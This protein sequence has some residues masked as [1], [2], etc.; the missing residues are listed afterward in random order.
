MEEQ[1][2]PGLSLLGQAVH[3][4]TIIGTTST[5]AAVAVVVVAAAAVAAAVVALAV[6]AD[7][8]VADAAA[9]AAVVVVAAAAS[10]EVSTCSLFIDE[11]VVINLLDAVSKETAR[12]A[13]VDCC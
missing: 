1:K 11:R 6:V 9:A 4:M 8:V 3:L 7:A 2:H 13:G 12:A 10:V 5:P